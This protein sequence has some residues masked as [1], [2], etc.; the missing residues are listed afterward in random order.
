MYEAFEFALYSLALGAGATLVIDLWALGLKR[1][2][3]VPAMNWGLVG[4]WI[5]HMPAGRFVHDSIGKATRIRGENAIGWVAHY[6]I[7]VVFAG[8][9][10]AICGLGWARQPTLSPALLVG[11]ATVTAPFFLM[12]P[13][14]GLGIAAA[15]TPKPGVARL[16]S[17][18]THTVFGL[19]LYGSAYLLA[20]FQP[21]T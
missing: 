12:Q 5:G 15:K 19:G 4:R 7:G 2:L 8:I 20:L 3:G 17:F 18:L 13:G 14:L 9:L 16:R 21:V 6:A 1:L 10:L 11:W